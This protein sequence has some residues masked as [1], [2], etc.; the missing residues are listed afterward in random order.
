MQA[1]LHAHMD[2]NLASRP[3]VDYNLA[4]ANTTAP[5]AHEDL[6]LGV[7][8]GTVGSMLSGLSLGPCLTVVFATLIAGG[9]HFK[10]VA[11]RDAALLRW[12]LRFCALSVLV[13][14]VCA[15]VTW[16]GS[17][18]IL[19]PG[20]THKTEWSVPC[21]IRKALFGHCDQNEPTHYCGLEFWGATHRLGISMLMVGSLYLVNGFCCLGAYFKAAGREK[22]FVETMLHGN[23]QDPLL[24]AAHATG[25]G[26][27]PAYPQ[28]AYP[29][30]HNSLAHG[31]H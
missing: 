13:S 14:F 25:G 3:V 18:M 5:V 27:H 6:E 24:M 12:S 17:A 23:P 16:V 2:I 30:D 1:W 26:L 9:L 10:G 20:Y 22:G 31:D 28:P 15:F 11:E 29:Q 19:A 4:S 21:S 7:L 8:Q